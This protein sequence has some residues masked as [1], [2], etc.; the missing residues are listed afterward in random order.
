MRIAKYLGVGQARVF[1]GVDVEEVAL[2]G[3]VQHASGLRSRNTTTHGLPREHGAFGDSL[4]EEGVVMLDKK[5]NCYVRIGGST[6]LGRSTGTYAEKEPL[7][8]V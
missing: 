2:E 1:E 5:D 4:H 3:Q 7:E 6:G 8:V